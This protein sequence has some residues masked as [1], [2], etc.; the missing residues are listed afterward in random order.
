MEKAKSALLVLL[1]GLSLLQSYFLA[2]SMPSMDVKVKTELDYV[3][4]D[5]IGNGEKIENL[6]F[7]EQMVLHMGEDQH[8]VFYPGTLPY[9]DIILSKLKSRVFKSIERISLNTI[10]WEEVRKEGKGVELRFSRPIP[11]ELLQR[12]FK[13]DTDFIFSTDAIDR[14]W[15]YASAEREEVRTFF[16]K[17]EGG[18]LYEALQADLT[19]LDIEGYIGFGQYWDRYVSVNGQLYVPEMPIDRMLEM[20]VD[21]SRYTTQQMQDNLFF[22]PNMIWTIQDRGFYTDNKRVLKIEE[23]SSW[24]TYTDLV[25]PTNVEN[26]Y[27]DNVIA[28]VG[29]VNNHGGWNGRHELV[30]EVHAQH[31]SAIRFMQYF[32][33]VPIVSDH[34]FNFGYMELAMQQGVVTSYN[35]SMIVLGDSITDKKPKKLVGGNELRI[36]ITNIERTGRTIAA[37]FPAYRPLLQEDHIVLSPV[38]AYRLENGDVGILAESRSSS[39]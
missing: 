13:I 33:N 17:S 25:A 5:P 4:A 8:T 10:D 30:P 16:F 34:R 20:T 9:Y 19:V 32:R 2:Y 22:D 29:F 24:L 18:S 14:I 12:V 1:V 26:N 6:I 7:P 35:R 38:W 28:A 37:L 3:S 23:S 39:P 27:V 11:F 21:Y 36:L 15:I 31:T